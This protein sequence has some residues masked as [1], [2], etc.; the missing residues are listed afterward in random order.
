MI[1]TIFDTPLGFILATV[2]EEGVLVLAR[3]LPAHLR[4]DYDGLA[5]FV[6]EGGVYV[7]A[8]PEMP[9][10]L[11]ALRVPLGWNG[12]AVSRDCVIRREEATAAVGDRLLNVCAHI[13]GELA[14]KAFAS[15]RRHDDERDAGLKAVLS[16]LPVGEA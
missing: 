5:V 4:D 11:N 15:W 8:F 6:K 9:G 13:A 12:E 10:L 16:R 7:A 1:H 14:T 3:T 2:G